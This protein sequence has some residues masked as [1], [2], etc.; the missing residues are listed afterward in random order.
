MK[1]S[2]TLRN[3][4][5]L[6]NSDHVHI[7]FIIQSSYLL[8]FS[9]FIF[10]QYEK[11]PFQKYFASSW[12]KIVKIACFG[13]FWKGFETKMTYIFY[14]SSVILPLKQ[15]RSSSNPT[16]PYQALIS[17]LFLSLKLFLQYPL[18]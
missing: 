4:L 2:S 1:A 6:N 17:S 15:S 12:R 14:N 11:K 13:A 3:L 9:F 7:V 18:Q 5:A 8:A 16:E 10:L